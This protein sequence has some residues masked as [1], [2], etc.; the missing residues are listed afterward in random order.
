MATPGEPGVVSGFPLLVLRIEGLVLLTLALVLYGAQEES[1]WLFLALL[2]A[3][4][5]GLLGLLFGKRVGA[6]TYDLTHNY[7][8]P[9]ALAVLGIVMGTDLLT[10]VAIVWFAHI[11][12]DR[13]LG[14][15]LQYPDGSGRTHLSAPQ[16]IAEAPGG[17]R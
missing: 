7:L 15:G 10:T 9:G 6:V 4:D 13:A 2:V 3:P 17:S 8:P 11:G 1:W 12:M 5:L 14:L 16:G